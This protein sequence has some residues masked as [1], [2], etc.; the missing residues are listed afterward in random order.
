MWRLWTTTSADGL[1]KNELVD[2][3]DWMPFN[4]VFVFTASSIFPIIFEIKD[5][6]GE[7]VRITV[8]SN[9]VPPSANSIQFFSIIKS[10]EPEQLKM[11][12]LENTV[13]ENDEAFGNILDYLL[14]SN[15]PTQ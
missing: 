14:S 8:E 3:V 11:A 12:V 7:V 2:N 9:T 15:T 4:K 6:G 13:S 5:S 1:T 10:N